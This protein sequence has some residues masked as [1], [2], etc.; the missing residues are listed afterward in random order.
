M[1][2]GYIGYCK[3]T[4]EYPDAVVYNYSG[5]NWNV[6]TNVS[7]SETAYDGVIYI[8]KAVLDYPKNKE[9]KY[10]WLLTAL[11]ADHVHIMYECKN[12]FIRGLIPIDY[13]AFRCLLK[14]FDKLYCEGVFIENGCFIQ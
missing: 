12:A 7:E 14:I 1:S 11:E 2:L 8:D 6:K 3:K 5:G 13:I 4:I 9:T 10:G